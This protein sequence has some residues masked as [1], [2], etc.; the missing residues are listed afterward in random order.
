M[1]TR[2][3]YSEH[4]NGPYENSKI[5]RYFGLHDSGRGYDNTKLNTII[6]KLFHSSVEGGFDEFRNVSCITVIHTQGTKGEND[7]GENGSNCHT[8][9][10]TFSLRQRRIDLGHFKSR[11]NVPPSRCMHGTDIFVWIKVDADGDTIG[12]DGL[13]PRDKDEDKD[14]DWSEIGKCYSR[15]P[16]PM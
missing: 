10:K 1:S 16:Y 14:I 7:K 8:H 9:I 15:R 13:I 12:I 4:L 3:R 2:N 6:D 5:S 11:P